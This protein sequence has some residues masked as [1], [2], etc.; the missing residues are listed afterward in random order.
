MLNI[1]LCS[2]WHPHHTRYSADIQSYDDCRISCV[3]DEVP[4]RGQ[5]WAAELG[6]V[7][8]ENDFATLLRRSDVDAVCITAPTSMHKDL[9]VAAAGAGKH[10]FT[11]KTL[12]LTEKDALEVRKAVDASGVIFT[13]AFVQKTAGMFI[14]AKKLIDSGIFGDITMMRIRNNVGSACTD[15]FS[16]TLPYWLDLAPTGGGAMTDLGCHP[17]YLLEWLL[18]KPESVCS[19]FAYYL[20]RECEDSAISSFVFNRGRTAAVVE[21]SY[22]T[23]YRSLY[24]FSFYGTRGTYVTRLC[25]PTIEIELP[26]GAAL[27]PCIEQCGPGSVSGRRSIYSV[28]RNIIPDEPPP[29]RCFVDACLHGAPVR[30]GIDEAVSLS[31]M[32][33]GVNIAHHQGIRYHFQTETKAE[34]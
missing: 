10:I 8:F 7:P 17:M 29:I 28:P 6:G 33:E 21:S 22:G 27:P 20:G 16:T 11:E 15:R 5:V 12:A 2:K 13:I 24:E 4:E 31:R 23:P 19:T 30:F 18:G 14:L 26:T 25:D 3:W 32:V 34:C 1:A 9:C